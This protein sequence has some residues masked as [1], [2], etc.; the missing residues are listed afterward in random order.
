MESWEQL[1]KDPGNWFLAFA[2]SA[3]VSIWFANPTPWRTNLTLVAIVIAFGISASFKV[4]G[5]PVAVKGLWIGV[6]ICVPGLIVYYLLWTE[7][8]ETLEEKKAALTSVE[9]TQYRDLVAEVIHI[10]EPKAYIS[11]AGAILGPDGARTV[12]IQFWPVSGGS[13]GPVIIDVVDS[14]DG[15]PVGIAAVD[16]AE[17][18]RRDVRANAMLLCSS[19]GFEPPAIR[20]AKRANIGLISV[21]KQG[22]KRIK[23]KIEEEIYLRK[24]DVT[25][26]TVTY[27]GE[28][29]HDNEILRKYMTRFHDVRYLG[30][31]VAAWL[32]QR[33][34]VYL[35]SNL[36][37]QERPTSD[38][39]QLKSPTTFSV[40]GHD[41]TVR[42]FSLNFH[43]RVQWLSQ[44][45]T[46]DAKTGIYDYVRGRVQLAGDQAN[47]YIISGVNFDTATAMAA[48]PDIQKLGVGLRPGEVDI[49]LS[50]VHGFDT[51]QGM[52]APDLTKLI[53]PEDLTLDIPSGVQKPEGS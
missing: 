42:A 3:F 8:V 48:P 44:I 45:V 50:M 1:Y 43:P 36:R 33:V 35:A 5:L 21:L 31:S 49:R 15:K 19:T 37:L 18:K 29:A 22:E 51:S 2:L 17:S 13:R 53:R 32:Q 30:G 38:R 28:T 16:A 10:L 39:Y 12:D 7:R 41:V 34:M 47:S 24:I 46:L 11:V 52:T 4:S 25:P 26:V 14:S 23:G 6:A 27:E 20:K 40:Q 9:D